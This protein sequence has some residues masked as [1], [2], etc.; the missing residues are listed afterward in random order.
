M[1]RTSSQTDLTRSQI[2]RVL[3]ER[4]GGSLS[5]DPPPEPLSLRPPSPLRERL[6]RAIAAPVLAGAAVFL[7][8]LIVAV[9]IV[10]SRPHHAEA[11]QP[12]PEP[13]A[14]ALVPTRS[15]QSPEKPEGSAGHVHVVG[16]V[17]N[18]GVF[19]MPAG[20]RV[21][22]ALEA[23]GGPLDSAV[24]SG[25]NLARPVQD[26]EEIVVPDASDAP[27]AT[28]GGATEPL[29]QAAVSAV[30]GAAVDINSADASALETLPR[31]GPALAARIVEWR[32]A[33]GRFRSL[34]DLLEVAGIGEK[35]LDGLRDS[36]RAG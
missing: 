9:A 13:A 11:V 17:K 27:S 10:W 1:P 36:A 29:P 12:S 16:A 23:A 15:T 28:A 24:L 25:V 34:D 35:I 7:I 5:L 22:A 19:R 14:A 2:R 33:N 21:E 20:A 3:A 31:I 26:G 4:F 18:P 6:R 8:A 32:E 30:P